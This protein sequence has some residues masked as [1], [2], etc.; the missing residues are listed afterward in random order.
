M[1]LAAART[2]A[3]YRSGRAAAL[4]NG[5]PES[6]YRA[7][8][9]GT[10]TIGLNDAERYA[11]RFRAVGVSVT[12]KGILYGPDDAAKGGGAVKEVVKSGSAKGTGGKRV[13]GQGALASTSSEPERRASPNVDLSRAEPAPLLHRFGGPRDVPEFGAAAGGKLGDADFRFNGQVVDMAPRPPGILNRKD[14]YAL[15]VTGESM[16][17]KFEEGDRIYVDPHRPP[18]VMDYV[19]VELQSDEDGENGEGFIKRLLRKTPSKVVVQQFNPAK[20]LEFDLDR[21]KG[22]H[23]VIPQDE[24]LGI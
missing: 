9:A 24:L 19:V 13:G 5:W 2:E 1:R 6:T 15:R 11:E 4:E 20:E 3:G 12:G 8:E 16:Y 14:V 18:R 22:L 10:R 21:V 7:H 17:P 23:R